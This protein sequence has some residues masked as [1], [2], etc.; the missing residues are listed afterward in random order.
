[1]IRGDAATACAGGGRR[2][3]LRALGAAA[4]HDAEEVDHSLAEL[5]ATGMMPSARVRVALV[6]LL[7]QSRQRK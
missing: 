1:M 2:G 7:R 6:A 5:L 4:G 3:A